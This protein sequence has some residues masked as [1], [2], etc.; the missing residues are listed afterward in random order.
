MPGT[1]NDINVLE[2]SH[3][4]SDLTQGIAPLAHYVIEGKNYDMGYF[5]TNGIYSKCSNIIQTINEH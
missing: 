5:L 3:L 1:N 2:S 4:I